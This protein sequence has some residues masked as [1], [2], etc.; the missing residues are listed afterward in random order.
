MDAEAKEAPRADVTQ[1]TIRVPKV[2]AAK[3]GRV[4][5]SRGV[6]I[7]TLVESEFGDAIHT[8]YADVIRS[9]HAELTATT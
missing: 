7:P 5:D 8:M 3:L 4:A 2:I 1:T 9:E 6:S